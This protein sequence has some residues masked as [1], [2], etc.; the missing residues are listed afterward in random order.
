MTI[1]VGCGAKQQNIGITLIQSGLGWPYNNLYRV[2]T[3]P[4]ISAG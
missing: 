4:V 2:M 1:F 3:F